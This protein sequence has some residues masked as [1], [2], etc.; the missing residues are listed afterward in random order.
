MFPLRVGVSISKQFHL[1]EVRLLDRVHAISLPFLLDH[2][3]LPSLFVR[4]D[5]NNRNV[6]NCVLLDW[7]QLIVVG[8]FV[9]Q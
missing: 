7:Y 9:L 6:F 1:F 5:N 2:T 8:C 4:V 3:F